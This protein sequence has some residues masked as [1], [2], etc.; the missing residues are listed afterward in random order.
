[1]LIATDSVGL[2]NLL[3]RAH[4]W[5]DKDG[6]GIEIATTAAAMGQVMKKTA[7]VW[8]A[9]TALPVSTDVLGVVLDATKEDSTKKR[10]LAKGE[11]IVGANALVYFAGATDPNKLA[12]NGFLETVGI[13][14]NTQI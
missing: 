8:A 7:G 1:M 9:I 11:A 12:I 6:Y 5:A 2:S 14:V 4:P 3:K 10:I 13:Q